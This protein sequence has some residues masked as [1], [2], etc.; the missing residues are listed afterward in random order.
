MTAAPL[1]VGL[2]GL[3][4]IGSVVARELLGLA[5]AVR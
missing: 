3:G 1:R 2:I 4:A 5:R